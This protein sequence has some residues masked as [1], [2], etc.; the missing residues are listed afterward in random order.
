MIS[1][2]TFKKKNKLNPRKKENNN[3]KI[4]REIKETERQKINETII[5]FIEIKKI[6]KLAKV[7][8]KSK[9]KMLISVMIR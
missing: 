2:S 1:T 4:R 8:L 7:I 9:H 5:N 6:E 3:N